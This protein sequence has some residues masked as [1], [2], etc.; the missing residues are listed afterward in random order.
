[1]D[2]PYFATLSHDKTHWIVAGA[3]DGAMI[4]PRRAGQVNDFDFTSE[5]LAQLYAEQYNRGI[6]EWLAGR[7]EVRI[8]QA[9]EDRAHSWRRA[10]E[11]YAESHPGMA[12]DMEDNARVMELLM[13]LGTRNSITE[14]AEK[15]PGYTAMPLPELPEEY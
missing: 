1:M 5:T 2:G 14:I 3:H 8:Y 10:A 12:S 6:A 9:L 11:M 13:R 7:E 15:I 4:A